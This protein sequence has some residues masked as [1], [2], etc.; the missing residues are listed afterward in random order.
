MVKKILELVLL[1]CF[2]GGLLYAGE[3]ALVTDI[4]GTVIATWLE[5]AAD[6][7]ENANS[8]RGRHEWPVELAEM[9]PA[10]ADIKTGKES[11]I[12][13]VHL[14]GNVEY[15]LGAGAFARITEE[16]I[17]GEAVA[18]APMQLVSTDINL[19]GTM[20]NQVGAVVSDHEHQQTIGNEDT[21][22]KGWKIRA[23]RSQ[24]N[25]IIQ[26][27]KSN[28]DFDY[29][30]DREE[31][32]KELKSDDIA[33]HASQAQRE[34]QAQQAQ[35]A[36]QELQALQALQTQQ[37]QQAQQAQPAPA[38][39]VKLEDPAEPSASS[40]G[41]APPAGLGGSSTEPAANIKKKSLPGET[42]FALP[43]EM[44][45]AV[46]STNEN[47]SVDG[48]E[49][50]LNTDYEGWVNFRFVAQVT[51]KD[52][53]LLLKGDKARRTIAMHVE[54]DSKASIALAWR[55]E[56]SGLLAQAASEW[57]QLQ[58]A[59]MD[60]AKVALHLKRIRNKMLAE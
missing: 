41:M 21:Y 27:L 43:E 1:M 26:T 53:A 13:L 58:A 29:V 23:S 6:G 47:L 49:I 19:D 11:A 2:T 37:A 36:L 4:S 15:T 10:G 50:K 34:L 57:L 30:A 3:V 9:L 56:K 60:E 16:G 14:T 39:P 40:D 52:F 20:R 45:A 18:S 8:E 38:A 28:D 24:N 46:R 31:K 5:P 17:E 42:G 25:G 59:G 48:Y 44:L 32:A 54:K 7:T 33:Q 22:D 12:T 51:D 55:L 35:Q